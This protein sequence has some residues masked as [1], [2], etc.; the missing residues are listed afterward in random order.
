MA[1][2]YFGNYHPGDP[3]NTKNKGPDWSEWELVKAAKPRFPGH[4][5]PRVPLWGYGDESDP[6][7]M[8]QK[9]AAAADPPVVV[10]VDYIVEEGLSVNSGGDSDLITLTYNDT[11]EHRAITVVNAVAIAYQEVGREAA[12]TEFDN[13]ILEL[14]T[15]IAALTSELLDVQDELRRLRT[16]DSNRLALEDQLL[17]KMLAELQEQD[18]LTFLYITHDLGVVSKV[19]DRICVMYAGIIAEQGK[20]EAVLKTPKHPYTQALLASLPNREKRG[21]RLYSIPGTVPNPAYKPDGC[22]FHP[23]CRHAIQTCREQYPEMCDYEDGHRARC[24]VIFNA[25]G[26]KDFR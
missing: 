8:E 22:P 17:R 14:E 19:A 13:A 21:R 9:I 18:E 15:S 10:T 23:R 11:S 24:P 1:S 12:T 2:Y 16:S 4:Q 3:R 20:K 7:V 5:Q 26:E 6:K 25:N